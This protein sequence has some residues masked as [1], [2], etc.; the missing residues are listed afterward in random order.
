[1]GARPQRSTP[2]SALREHQ[3]DPALLLALLGR[4][5][6]RELRDAHAAHDLTPS[7][8]HLLGLLDEHNDRGQTELATAMDTAASVLVGLLNPLEKRQLIVRARDVTDRRRHIV[9]L[10][11]AGQHLFHAA[12]AA[13]RAVQDALFVGLTP[14]QR[15]QLRDLLREVQRTLAGQPIACA[16]EE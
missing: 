10:T 8:F 11:Q 14:A 12:L 2:T 16:P 5:A 15:A 7:Q 1:M 3:S 6:T 9:H 4:R 13:Q